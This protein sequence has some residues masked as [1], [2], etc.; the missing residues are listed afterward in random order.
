M[1]R[2]Y[3]DSKPFPHNVDYLAYVE[4]N[5]N[6]AVA[7]V[8]AEQVIRNALQQ[9]E[10]A[11]A[12]EQ[13]ERTELGRV[14][15][16]L[17]IAGAVERKSLFPRVES[18]KS[19]ALDAIRK[20][21]AQSNFAAASENEGTKNLAEQAAKGARAICFQAVEQLLRNHTPLDSLVSTQLQCLG[22]GSSV[23]FS[24]VTP[25]GVEADFTASVPKEHCWA[26]APRVSDFAQ[27][28]EIEVAQQVGWFSK[29][30]RQVRLLLD[31]YF[32]S[33]LR[34][35]KHGGSF[36]LL[37]SMGGSV[38]LD[39]SISSE[40]KEP[41]TAQVVEPEGAGRSHSPFPLQGQEA[42][43]ILTLHNTMAD[44]VANLSLSKTTLV[45][46]TYEEQPLGELLSPLA[47]AKAVIDDMAPL[48]VEIGQRSGAPGELV[49]RRTIG[50]RLREESYL[51]KE[52]LL[53]KL[54]AFRPD[55]QKVFEPLHLNLGSRPA[56]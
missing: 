53:V 3:G 11:A 47:L 30:P 54:S 6:C 7:L 40:A 12:A 39:L 43:A 29:R 36:R 27:G 44:S 14:L 25:F 9:V 45:S 46:A 22:S 52:E 31:R 28:I 17:E 33:K 49:L 4:A 35:E 48:V 24:M 19:Q 26:N 18:V 51:R 34:V 56:S 32:V 23:L 5:F 16:C 20:I 38:G 41:V 10:Q 21:G 55:L 1:S 13:D 15:H 2:V 8:A 42:A 37:K 50:K